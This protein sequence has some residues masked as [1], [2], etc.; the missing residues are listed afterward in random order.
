MAAKQ[1]GR[2]PRN[3]A[4][5]AARTRPVTVLVV[6]GPNLNLLGER[7]PEVYGRIR[8]RDIDRELKALA[9][10]LG[11]TLEAFQSNSEGAIIDRIQ[12]ARGTTDVILINPGGYTHTSVA[13]RD[14]L[15]AVGAPVIEVHL[16]NIYRREPFRRRSTIADIAAGRIMGFGAES[17]YLALRAA[18][19]LAQSPRDKR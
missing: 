6:H 16:S 13:I 9:R 12:G 7:E 15:L 5:D 10:E 11:M 14:A 18:R 2:A 1:G 19:A 3:T 17:Y 4:A 8:L